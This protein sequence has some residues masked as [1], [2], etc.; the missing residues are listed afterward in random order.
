[1]LWTREGTRV[2]LYSFSALADPVHVSV[3]HTASHCAVQP[4]SSRA[5]GLLRQ[6]NAFSSLSAV[7][8]VHDWLS[9]SQYKDFNY[10][11]LA[12]SIHFGHL[13]STS[14]ISLLFGHLNSLRPPP[15]QPE[16]INPLQSHL[17]HS[18][19]KY[20]YTAVSV[21]ARATAKACHGNPRSS[22]L[23]AC[24]CMEGCDARE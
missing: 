12:T 10:Y 22:T 1:M 8:R 14:A 5:R 23:S 18:S 19:Q 17:L 15:S 9:I 2:R 6:K 21:T 13:T 7:V 20:T 3:P 4:A 11:S 24:A 16:Q